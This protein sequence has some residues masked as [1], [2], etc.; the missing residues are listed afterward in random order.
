MTNPFARSAGQQNNTP[1]PAADQA[2][3]PAANTNQAAEQTTGQPAPKPALNLSTLFNNG[4]SAG[5]DKLT[6]LE[7][8]AVLIRANKYTE[9]MQT[10]HGPANCIEADWVELDGPGQGTEHSGLIFSTVIVNSLRRYMEQGQ[11]L[12]VGVVE[13]GTAKP[14]KNAPWLLNPLNDEQLDLAGKAVQALNWA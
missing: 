13:K 6:D 7:G 10:Q 3:A 8:V 2:P 1:A 14:G 5:G 11:N 4:A 12:S 9:N